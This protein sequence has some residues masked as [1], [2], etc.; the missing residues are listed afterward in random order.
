MSHELYTGMPCDKDGKDL[1]EHSPPPSAEQATDGKSEWHPFTSRLEFDFAWYHFVEMESS[2]RNLNRGL[3][4]WAA[5]VLQHGGTAPWKSSDALYA[6]IDKIQCG[7]APWKTYK[8]RYQGPLPPTPPQWMTCT[9]EL[10]VRDTR[11]VL[12]QQFA[13]PGFKG[14]VDYAPYKQFNKAGKRVWSHF[15]SGDWV[16]KQAVSLNP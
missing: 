5:S 7:D 14:K 2:E 12:H 13:N 8:F 6:A 11:V 10:C 15:M 3:D 9:Y 4:L 16:W 1:A